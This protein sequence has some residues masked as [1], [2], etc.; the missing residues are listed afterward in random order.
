MLRFNPVAMGDLA[1]MQREF[2]N[3][4]TGA[5]GRVHRL[6]AV[7]V[8]SNENEAHL[9][10]ELPGVDPNDL[11]ISVEGDR[12][13]LSG[14]RS[15]VDAGESGEFHRRERQQGEFSRTLQLPFRVDAQK[16]DATM[17]KGVLTVKLPRAEEDKPKKIV[18]K[19]A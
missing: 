1:L 6:P 12:V 5:N 4:F 18:I 16:V 3:L 8:W 7:N 13:T 17:N 9:T 14:Q 2:D 10:A 15:R 19:V 11:T